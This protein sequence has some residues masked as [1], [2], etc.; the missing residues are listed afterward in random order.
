MLEYLKSVIGQRM[1]E[2]RSELQTEVDDSTILEYASLFQE[3]DDLTEK[4]TA[5]ETAVRTPISIPLEDDIELDSIEIN[6]TDGRVTDIPA[7]ATVNEFA[8]IDQQYAAM[9]TYNEFYTEAY[10]SMS[11]LPRES[12]EK[13]ENRVQMEASRKWNAY[14][15]YL[16]Q[17]GVFGHGK[18]S[19]DDISVPFKMHL[20]FGQTSDKD[21]TDYTVTLTVGYEVD[22][23]NRVTKK[24]LDSVQ[25]FSKF[26]KVGLQ[27][28]SDDVF[29]HICDKYKVNP[30]KSKWDVITPINVVVPI[31][32]TDKYAIAIG[33]ETEF[34]K[35]ATY[36][37]LSIPVKALNV[38]KN[39]DI[40]VPDGAVGDV[41]AINISSLNK[42][43]NKRE[44]KLEQ[45]ELHRP[46]RWGSYYQEA[47]DFG[48]DSGGDANANG[49]GTDAPPV[50]NADN[51]NNANVS[52]DANG[53]ND[54]A[55]PAANAVPAE[56]N[57]VSDQ[58]AD[59]VSDITSQQQNVQS[60]IDNGSDDVELDIDNTDGGN[61]VELDVQNENP[62]DN[63][64]NDN[65][66]A[67]I[68]DLDISGGT[69]MADTSNETPDSLDDMTIDE[70]I[71][72]GSEKLKGMTINQLKS[73]ITAPDG[74]TPEDVQAEDTA[75]MEYAYSVSDEKVMMENFFSDASN[76]KKRMN[77]AINDVMPGLNMIYKNCSNGSWDRY[78][79]REFWASVR[80]EDDPNDFSFDMS[81]EVRKGNQFRSYVS[82]LQHYL[83]VSGKKRA[84]SAFTESDLSTLKQCNET[85]EDFHKICDKASSKFA[86]KND[87]DMSEVGAKAKIAI[88]ACETIR[89]IITSDEYTEFYIQEAAFITK[90]NVTNEMGAHIASSLGILNDTKSSFPQ[91]VK[92]FTSESKALNKILTKAGKMNSVYTKEELVEINKLNS[93]LTELSSS[94]RLNNLNTQ[95]TNKIKG[96][97]KDYA[98]QCK[99]VGE[100]VNK[101]T[102]KKVV[103]ESY[104]YQ[105]GTFTTKKNVKSRISNQL[106][107]VEKGI[108]TIHDGI[109]NKNW[110]KH[111]LLKFWD[112][113]RV[114]FSVTGGFALVPVVIASLFTP[115]IQNS[116]VKEGEYFKDRVNELIRILNVGTK[117]RAKRA[118]D[119]TEKDTLKAFRTALEDFHETCAMASRKF[120]NDKSL[121]DV[122]KLCVYLLNEMPKIKKIVSDEEFQEACQ[123]C[124]AGKPI[125]EDTD[126]DV[127]SGTTTTADTTTGTDVT[128]STASSDTASSA[129]SS[130]S[131]DGLPSNTDY[132]TT[133]ECDET[134]V[135]RKFN[136]FMNEFK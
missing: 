114:G 94:I 61:D 81:T 90:K 83:K 5:I 127:S 28:M 119:K 108:Q 16:Y 122:D 44:F 53:G 126:M 130:P 25:V 9:K 85:L 101:K 97:I 132:N 71:A 26:G 40:S 23:K 46:R 65:V 8:Q 20:N 72:Q 105:E 39:N 6:L 64:N 49:G 21:K 24:Q 75:S 42:I 133:Q 96:L 125:A 113:A 33:F 110:S 56:V 92:M 111:E 59:K 27:R 55:Q 15:D 11:P 80:K 117:R 13:F 18:V 14:N 102:G 7:D 107:C 93:I 1:D 45:H 84:R 3:L 136:E 17:E 116:S 104:I 43:T 70:L 100:I 63:I 99:V 2:Q 121:K 38:R 76:I 134:D 35:E 79:L 54:N 41:A 115:V 12:R 30:K 37:V 112:D 34:S 31:N 62:A 131:S 120:N 86:I 129:D 10:N 98:K 22:K 48:G 89:G 36:W 51:G 52:V 66:D 135:T 77:T 29:K 109:K 87:K 124:A 128:T 82:D 58:I 4:G 78:K 19:I 103:G 68:D 47:I 118:F 50:D 67:S 69:D 123:A 106:D 73:F 95:Y 60:P 88:E 91:L 74:T 57:D 32:P